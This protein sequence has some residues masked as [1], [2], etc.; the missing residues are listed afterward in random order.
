MHFSGAVRRA[1]AYRGNVEQL[2]TFKNCTH[3]NCFGKHFE[4][5]LLRYGQNSAYNGENQTT[6]LR[7]HIFKKNILK[8]LFKLLNSAFIVLLK[9]FPTLLNVFMR[10]WIIKSRMRFAAAALFLHCLRRPQIN[11]I[12][13]PDYLKRA[14]QHNYRA[15]TFYRGSI[16]NCQIPHDVVTYMPFIPSR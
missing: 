12:R 4:N 13:S 16:D 2:T 10:K 5:Y 7:T 15:K 6:R 11:M 8:K 1:F 9:S 14:R 3:R